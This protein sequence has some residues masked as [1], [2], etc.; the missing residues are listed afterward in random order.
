MRGLCWAALNFQQSITHPTHL[1]ANS[2]DSTGRRAHGIFSPLNGKIQLGWKMSSGEGSGL[3]GCLWKGCPLL[4]SPPQW[5]RVPQNTPLAQMGSPTSFHLALV[6]S[7][8]NRRY[9]RRSSS[10]INNRQ[11]TR[12]STPMRNTPAM[13]LPTISGTLGGCGHSMGQTDGVGLQPLAK[14]RGCC[15]RVGSLPV[16]GQEE[17][18]WDTSIKIDDDGVHLLAILLDH[19][20]GHPAVLGILFPAFPVIYAHLC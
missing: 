3:H 17:W 11:M 10:S 4:L 1:S 19:T 7:F 20:E 9:S 16:A 13:V 2:T 18:G 15:G 12:T 6:F 5:I 8:S 14:Q